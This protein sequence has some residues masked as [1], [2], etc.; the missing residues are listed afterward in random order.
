[1]R[2]FGQCK[3]AE[4]K[5][6]TGQKRA[7]LWRSS[8]RIPL[9]ILLGTALFLFAVSQFLWISSGGEKAAYTPPSHPRQDVTQILENALSESGSQQGA[10]ALSSEQYRLLGQQTG[11]SSIAIDDLLQEGQSGIEEILQCQDNRYQKITVSCNKIGIV[12]WEEQLCNP[13]G[14]R[15]CGFF[16]PDLKKGD[17]LVSMNDYS[18]GWRHGHAGIVVDPSAGITLESVYMGEPSC[19]Q[20]IKKWEGYPHVTLLRAKDADRITKDGHRLGDLVADYAEEHMAGVPYSL[21]AGFP[22]KSAKPTKPVKTTQCAHLVWACWEHFGYDL[23]PG[24]GWAV[25]PKQIRDSKSLNLIQAFG[26]SD[27]G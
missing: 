25:T 17:I 18:L 20:S 14:S 23:V 26:T 3:R 27:F 22:F 13:D 11:L 21:F 5:R 24:N 6:K 10:P 16:F 2:E 4:R 7:G 8:I 19:F 12:T 15:A 1:M 9:W